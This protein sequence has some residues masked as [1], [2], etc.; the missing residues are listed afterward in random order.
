MLLKVVSLDGT[1]FGSGNSQG[2]FSPTATFKIC[3]RTSQS[4]KG[5]NFNL[6]DKDKKV[7]PELETA[8]AKGKWLRSDKKSCY[9]GN[10]SNSASKKS[11]EVDKNDTI[12][13]TQPVKSINVPSC[14][15]QIQLFIEFPTT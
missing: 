9:F 10:S 1:E 5:S 4:A 11:D 13:F 7:F 6:R 2:K 12:H 3:L 15:L 14:G 8:M